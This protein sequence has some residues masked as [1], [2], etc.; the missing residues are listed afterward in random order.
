MSVAQ[1]AWR[2]TDRC[3]VVR[4]RHAGLDVRRLCVFSLRE[5]DDWSQLSGLA[6]PP[7]LQGLSEAW[8]LH[9]GL[10]TC[11]K[12]AKRVRLQY[13]S[14]QTSRLPSG[15]GHQC[16]RPSK[17]LCAMHGFLWGRT[18]YAAFTEGWEQLHSLPRYSTLSTLRIRQIIRLPL[19]E[20]VG[21]QLQQS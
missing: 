5:G 19:C 18:F 20:V 4:W 8:P 10:G 15:S 14:A 12:K 3:E 17:R 6:R 1:E 11:L 9:G 7:H 16:Q 13:T 2:G 21:S